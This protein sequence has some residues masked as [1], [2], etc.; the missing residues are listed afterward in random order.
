M[1][2]LFP[3]GEGAGYAG[4]LEHAATRERGGQLAA[5]SNCWETHTRC[6]HRSHSLCLLHSH[7]CC[8]T[9]CEA[10]STTISCAHMYD[11]ICTSTIAKVVDARSSMGSDGLVFFFSGCCIF[12]T[13]RVLHPVTSLRPSFPLLSTAALL[14]PLPACEGGIV[15]AAVDGIRVGQSVAAQVLSSATAARKLET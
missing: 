10:A 12:K 13:P 4:K 11:M 7:F 1:E 8:S 3:T 5:P 15:S 2:G 14:L 6:R 9:K